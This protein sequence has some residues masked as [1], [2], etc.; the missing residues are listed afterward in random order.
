MDYDSEL[1]AS[2]DESVQYE[3]EEPT[4]VV[5]EEINI[6][7]LYDADE[8]WMTSSTKEIYPVRKIDDKELVSLK[9]KSS[10][11]FKVLSS[12]NRQS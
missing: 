7:Q 11:W 8:I 3:E 12:F 6:L 5:E 9:P 4:P 2:D 1:V 10:I